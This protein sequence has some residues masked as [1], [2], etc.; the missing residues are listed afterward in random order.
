MKKRRSNNH[1]SGIHRFS[2]IIKIKRHC[3]QVPS[4]SNAHIGLDIWAVWDETFWN[5]W[6]WSTQAALR[7]KNCGTW[8][9]EESCAGSIEVLQSSLLSQKIYSAF[10]WLINAQRDRDR[11]L[12]EVE[13]LTANSDG[14]TQKLEDVHAQKLKSLEAQVK[15]LISIF[16][17]MIFAI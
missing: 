9:W 14:Q 6:C 5:I 16:I 10:T 12:A 1:E 13:N 2:Y 15:D 17:Q 4:L 11:L 8:G 7:T 3:S